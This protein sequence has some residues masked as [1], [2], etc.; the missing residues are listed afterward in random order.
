MDV[1]N[2]TLPAKGFTK[3][4]RAWLTELIEAIKTVQGVAGT[5]TS[6]TNTPHGQVMNLKPFEGPGSTP[7]RRRFWQ[8]AS[9]AV[10]ASQKMAGH[11]VTVAEHPGKGTIINV[12]RRPGVAPTGACCIGEDCSITT[13]ADCIAA[14]GTYQGDNTDCDPNPCAAEGCALT[15]RCDDDEIF[16]DSGLGIAA[17]PA[18]AWTNSFPE[19]PSSCALHFGSFAI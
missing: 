9:A 15:R 3:A 16:R 17:T 8:A 12:E 10:L 2:L 5:N 6:I 14:G 1:L 4:E 19:Q 7:S 13:E 11:H 18:D